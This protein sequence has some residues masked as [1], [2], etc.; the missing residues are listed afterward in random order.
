MASLDGV[1]AGYV[2]L[3]PEPGDPQTVQVA[4][5]GL[6]QPFHGRGI[7]G[8]LL[9]HGLRRAFALALPPSRV[10]VHTCSLDG[11]HALTNYRARGM[12]LTNEVTTAR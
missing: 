8:A 7:G 10:W 11:P 4:Y 9:L 6:L 2:E 5:F 12:R 1:E 3:R